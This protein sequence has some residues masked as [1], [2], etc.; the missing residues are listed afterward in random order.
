LEQVSFD[1]HLDNLRG[2]FTELS[3]EAS[4][5]DFSQRITEFISIL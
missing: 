4:S 3:M 5:F 2:K 1:K